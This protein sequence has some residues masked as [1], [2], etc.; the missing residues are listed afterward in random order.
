MLGPRDRLDLD[1][2]GL[3]WPGRSASRI[4]PSGGVRWHVQEA[5]D[6]PCVLLLHGAG[7]ATHSW[8][9]VFAPLARSAHVIAVDLPGHAFSGPAPPGRATL[10]GIAAL[11]GELMAT[12][13]TR[14]TLIVGHSA[15]A[16]VALQMVAAS[17]AAPKGI[18]A[19]NGALTPFR[20]AAGIAFPQ[21]ARMLALNPFV[22][23]FIARTASDPASVRRLLA[24]T[25]SEPSERMVDLYG[26]L[27]AA[28]SH[29][30]GTL[31]MMAGWRLEPLLDALPDIETPVTAVLAKGDRAVP[32]SETRRAVATL[33]HHDI[34]EVEGG[35]LWHED[36]PAEA[37]GL[38]EGHLSR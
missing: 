38:I 5:G 30:R 6:G 18:I 22:P 35:H 13:G 27:V 32:P 3:D 19:I 16:A 37:L 2:D 28:P 8:G 23:R 29:V 36:R 31:D 1:R 24:A 10:P 7:G 4:V 20:G 21:M 12:L 17:I 25:G 15:G 11:L 34:L 33:P 26:R 9:G 14:P